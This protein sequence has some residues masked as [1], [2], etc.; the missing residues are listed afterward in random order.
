MK[1]GYFMRNSVINWMSKA[2]ALL[3]AAVLSLGLFSCVRSEGVDK[4]VAERDSLK[5]ESLSLQ[6]R[7]VDFEELVSIVN[8]GMDS[9]MRS[10]SDLFITGVSEGGLPG[11]EGVLRNLD[12]LQQIVSNQKE[13][14]ALMEQKLEAQR[15]SGKSNR[16]SEKER[17][18]VNFR[19]QLTEKDAQIASL[20][21]ELSKKDADI[22]SLRVKVGAQSQAIAELDRRNTLQTEALKRQDAALNQCY[23]AIGTKKE[24]Q[25]KGIIKKGKI[26]T[27][28]SFDRSKFA[29]IDIRRATE[30]EFTAKRPRILTPMP[31]NSYSLT[32]D[33]D[34]KYFLHITN[35][36]SFWSMS[37]ILIIQTN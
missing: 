33:G 36:T 28:E 26:V 15:D 8:D 30:F 32:T 10:E 37:N 9:I 13:R 12:K 17:L 21:Q 5:E 27:K 25:A 29:K 34:G 23:M 11:K 7:L 16:N 1:A 22:S 4:I 14:I 24:L 20:R 31:E 19:R 3:V 6:A 35:P 18:I 2:P